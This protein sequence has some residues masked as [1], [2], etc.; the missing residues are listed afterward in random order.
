MSR[1]RRQHLFAQTIH[2][3]RADQRHQDRACHPEVTGLLGKGLGMPAMTNV[4][5][6]RIG[7][8]IVPAVLLTM[9]IACAPREARL[10]G[11]ATVPPGS[12]PTATLD[13]RQEEVPPQ[14]TEV[15]P[16]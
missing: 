3:R 8:A 7:F 4:V 9:M 16:A 1:R 14:I 11:T 6:I 2:A 15:Q 10:S 13:C 5:F 12:L